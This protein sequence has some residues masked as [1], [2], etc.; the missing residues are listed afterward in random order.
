M[1]TEIT[2]SLKKPIA[3]QNEQHDQSTVDCGVIDH[4]SSFINS[5]QFRVDN[6]GK[7]KFSS[8]FDCTLAFEKNTKTCSAFKRRCDSKRDAWVRGRNKF[9]AKRWI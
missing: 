4:D 6:T 5:F 8:I 2:D 3:R 9:V 1:P 7:I